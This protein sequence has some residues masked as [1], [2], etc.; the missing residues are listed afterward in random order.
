MFTY[1]G[2][3]TTPDVS[4][5]LVAEDHA[6]FW[7]VKPYPVELNVRRHLTGEA[8]DTASQ[9]CTAAYGQITAQA[10]AFFEAYPD[11]DDCYLMMSV[12]YQYFSLFLFRRPTEDVDAPE[13]PA[14][15]ADH[16]PS[17]LEREAYEKLKDDLVQKMVDSALKLQILYFCEEMSEPV[18][19]SQTDWKPT[20]K[21]LKAMALAMFGGD[22]K[23]AS[24]NLQFSWLRC[25]DAKK[26]RPESEYTVS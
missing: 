18:P 16:E 17:E 8:R 21:V 23:K 4:F 12:G 14:K 2:T 5:R 13:I 24:K 22:L 3:K 26:G 7:E 11:I 9:A 10:F 15:Y 25:V 6:F 1:E 20:D 19:D